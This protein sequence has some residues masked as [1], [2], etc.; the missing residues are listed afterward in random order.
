MAGVRKSALVTLL[1]ALTATIVMI[2]VF[3]FRIVIDVWAKQ[4]QPHQRS[5]CAPYDEDAPGA[6]TR[7]KYTLVTL[8]LVLGAATTNGFFIL[9]FNSIYSELAKR[10]TE[11]ENHRT[12]VARVCR[13]CLS[14]MRVE[15][16]QRVW[17]LRVSRV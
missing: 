10:L 3:A 6:W 16:V 11:W 9:I 7:S 17:R 1:C 14:N 15:H 2:S 13:T 8:V 5:S 12:Q 4:G